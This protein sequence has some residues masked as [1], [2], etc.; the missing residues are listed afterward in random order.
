MLAAAVTGEMGQTDVIE[1]VQA[2]VGNR[3]NVIEAYVNALD[4]LAADVASASIPVEH[5][6]MVDADA[7]AQR[8][9]LVSVLALTLRVRG[10]IGATFGFMRRTVVGQIA[11]LT[12]TVTAI[13]YL[14]RAAAAAASRL[15]ELNAAPRRISA[16]HRAVLSFPPGYR[17]SQRLKRP[18]ALLAKAR[19]RMTAPRCVP[20]LV[21]APRTQPF[22]VI[23]ICR[24]A[25][26]TGTL[27]RHRTLQRVVSWGRSADEA[28]V[29]SIL[30]GIG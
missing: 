2:T 20:R 27:L 11:A 9:A 26:G 19:G 21:I 14:P 25:L 10:G 23:P 12:E 28:R 4:G 13:A 17:L 24:A 16:I 15:T 8:P 3:D 5:G 22:G 1:T 6:L 18:A 7:L 30:A 29:P